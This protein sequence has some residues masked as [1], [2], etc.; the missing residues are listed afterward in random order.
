VAR[1]DWAIDSAG[2][3]RARWFDVVVTA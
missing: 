3:A 2:A 1:G